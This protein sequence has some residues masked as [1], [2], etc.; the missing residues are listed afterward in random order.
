MTGVCALLAECLAQSFHLLYPKLLEEP[1]PSATGV[2]LLQSTL[3]RLQRNSEPNHIKEGS[4]SNTENSVTLRKNEK[5]RIYS[6]LHNRV[7]QNMRR[8]IN[9][10]TKTCEAAGCL[11]SSK[12]GIRFFSFPRD[13]ARTKFNRNKRNETSGRK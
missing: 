4:T 8:S 2:E 9:M 3:N 11:S 13:P 6:D 5:N 7:Q 1:F 10:K 12:Q